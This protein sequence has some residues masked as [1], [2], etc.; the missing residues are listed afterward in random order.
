MRRIKLKIQNRRSTA[1]R[2][3]QTRK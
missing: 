3:N 2:P 1:D